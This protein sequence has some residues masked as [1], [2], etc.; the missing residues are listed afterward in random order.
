MLFIINNFIR[1]KILPGYKIGNNDLVIDIGSG[2]KPF[3]R[4]NVFLDKTSLANNQR[5]T[6]SGVVKDIGIFV[7]GDITKTKFKRKSFDFSFCSHLLEHVE[8]PDLAIAEIMR[9]S[10]RGYI[11]VPNGILESIKPFS[12]HLWF[13]YEVN[14]TLVFYRKSKKIHKVLTHNSLRYSYLLPLIH[15]PFIRLYWETNINFEIVDPYRKNEKF[16]SLP[17]EGT[18]ERKKQTN[19]YLLI[20]K[21]L[22]KFHGV[23]RK[24]NKSLVYEK[25]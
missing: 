17:E 5:F 23:D 20:V 25:K 3:W 4:A 11:E 2:D 12:S 8:R 18:P 24:I 13:V 21:I 16:Y 15:R 6:H 7:D 22:R 9:I 1:G 14:N 19:T 10:K